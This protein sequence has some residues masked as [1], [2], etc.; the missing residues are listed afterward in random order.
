MKIYKFGGASV[1]DADGVKNLLKVL[2]EVGYDETLII[3][4]AMGKMT[5]AFEKIASS[6]YNKNEEF[7]IYLKTAISFH[8]EIIELLFQGSKTKILAEIDLIFD[9]LLFFTKNNTV[10]DYNYIYDQIVSKAEL[11]STKICSYYLSENG[12]LNTWLDVREFIK[13]NSDFRRA[14]VDWEK[15]SELIKKNI[16]VSTLN[17]TQGFIA[18]DHK[19][20]TTTLGREGSDYT[21]GIFAYCLDAEKTIIFKD[22][23]GVLNADPRNFEDTTLLNQISYREAI[24]M[25]FYG[26]SVIHPKTL[27]PLQRKEIPLFVKSFKNPKNTGTV[28]CRGA[29]L[30][31]KTPCFIVKKNQILLSISAKDFSFIMEDDI[32]E[33]FDFFHQYKLKVNL[34]QNSAISF[35]VCLEDNFNAFNKLYEKLKL[36]YLC[37]YNKNVSLFTIRHFTK[38]SILKIEKNKEVLVKQLSRETV[39]LVVKN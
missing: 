10:K 26:A 9:E 37:L 34:I 12:I 14:E 35:S 7:P 25:A 4:S 31:P 1:K 19:N 17:I 28:V 6:Y 36:N 18:S 29:N 32:S 2:N 33:I 22:V 5:N 38:A 3:I 24:E 20:N 39:Q 21:A 11:I 13:T 16:S 30:V 27:Q 8:K 15:T 23:A